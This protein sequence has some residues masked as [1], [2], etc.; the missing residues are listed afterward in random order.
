M[1]FAVDQKAINLTNFEIQKISF[2][3]LSLSFSDHSQAVSTVQSDL[4]AKYIFNNVSFEF[5]MLSNVLIEA[6]M[7]SGRS[8]LLKLLA[9]LVMPNMGEYWI[10]DILISDLSFEEFLHIRLKI[11][12]S[13]DYGGLLANQSL[14]NNLLIPILYHNQVDF[15]EAENRVQEL[16]SKFGLRGSEMQR[17]A[18]VSGSLRK[19]TVVAR[20]FVMNPQMLLLDDP[21]VG[22]DDKQIESTL[23]LISDHRRNRNLKHVYFTTRDKKYLHNIEYQTIELKAHEFQLKR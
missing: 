17:P 11:G 9:G 1:M 3:N 23:E 13:F 12:Y 21:F 5:P 15:I 19:A 7:G 20:S 10:N 4:A 2:K 16:I 18:S 22:L 6:P 14:K 8:T